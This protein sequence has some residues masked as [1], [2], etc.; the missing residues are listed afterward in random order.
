MIIILHI[1]LFFKVWKIHKCVKWLSLLLVWNWCF[2]SWD[3]LGNHGHVFAVCIIS[4]H[5]NVQVVEMH[6]N[7]FVMRPANE[8]QRYK[9]HR[10]PLAGYLHKVIP[11]CTLKE[12]KQRVLM[13]GHQGW[14]VRHGLCHIYMIY[15]YIYIWVLYSFCLVC[16]LF[17]IVTTVCDKAKAT[18][19]PSTCKYRPFR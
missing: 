13:H 7:H 5:W 4:W 6:R 10:H 12:D 19:M 8:R 3:F 18:N 15:V 1:H 16:C 2:T 17:I 14:N 11:G 9:K